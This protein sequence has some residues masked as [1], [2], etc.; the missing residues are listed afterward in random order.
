MG[1]VFKFR[2]QSAE[3]VQ[4]FPVPALIHQLAAVVLTMDVHQ[5]L[6]QLFHL[7][8]GG[9]HTADAAAALP[10][11]AYSALKYQLIL[12]LESVIFQPSLAAFQIKYRSHHA[13]FGSTAHQFPADPLSKHGADGVDDDGFA[14]SGLAGQHIEALTEA[15]VGSLYYCDILNVKFIKHF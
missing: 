8:G 6:S 4:I 1:V 14:R 2:L 9:R 5:Q 7:G 13:F 3:P 10:V 12:R 15:D 11:G